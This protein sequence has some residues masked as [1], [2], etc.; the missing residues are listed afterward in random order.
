MRLTELL[1]PQTQS[2][3]QDADGTVAEVF[4]IES[5]TLKDEERERREGAV[6]ASVLKMCGKKP[7]YYYIRTRSELEH[8]AKRFTRSRYRYLHISCHGSDMALETTLDSVDYQDFAKIFEGR[9]DGRRLFVS[10][11]SAGNEIFADLVYAKNA[12][13]I[14]LAAPALDI[15]FDHAVAFWSAFYVKA[16]SINS[17]SMR[18]DRVA[19]VIK[20]L[21]KLFEV[22]MH[23]ARKD[24]GSGKV[25]H[26]QFAVQVEK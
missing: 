25:K 21:T 14:S 7:L 24:K 15:Y 10:A 22:P 18:S 1:Q 17:T 23:W 20:A 5:L 2:H 26:E 9:L 3:K 16:F 8:L 12:K 19:E 6:L 11:C 4:I 13:L